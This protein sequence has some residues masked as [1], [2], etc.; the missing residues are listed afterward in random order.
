MLTAREQDVLALVARA[1]TSRAVAHRLGISGRTVHEHL[2]H[3]SRELGC[4]DRLSAVLGARA[5][6]L[7]A[8]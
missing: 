4:C 3:A 2:E 6:G 1:L 5:E 8:T 7:I